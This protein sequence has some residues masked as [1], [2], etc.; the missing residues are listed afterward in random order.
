MIKKII[1]S[2]PVL[3]LIL[4]LLFAPSC[5]FKPEETSV[6]KIKGSDTMLRLTE[7][8]AEE[9]MKQ[10]PGISVYVEG[11]GTATGIKALINDETDICTASRPLEPD[12]AK[13]LAHYYQSLAMVYLVAKD[14]LSIYVNEYNPVKYL[15]LEMIKNIYQCKIKNWKELGGKDQQII[16]VS[17]N[18]NSGTYLY[19][20]D[21]VLF[22]E[23]YCEEIVIQPTTES[24]IEFVHQN[25]NAIGYGAGAL[26]S[27]V[28]TA[29]VDGIKPSEESARNDTY[30]ITRYLHFFTRKNPTGNIKQFIDWTLKPGGQKVIKEVGFI[31]LWQTPE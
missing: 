1:P 7:R 28:F 22:G 12:E 6:I 26:A 4:I 5:S 25:E 9:F 10:H 29:F 15:T 27:G 20:K 24:I 19:F 2:S 30:P 23:D 11:G 14:A 3:L 8:L 18:P 17:R 21:H 16:P 31:P 13:L